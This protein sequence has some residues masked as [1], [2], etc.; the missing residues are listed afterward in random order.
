MHLEKNFRNT[1]FI[2]KEILLITMYTWKIFNMIIYN[3]QMAC[4]INLAP[5]LLS[6]ANTI[7]L[8][9]FCYSY[10]IQ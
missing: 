8:Q 3:A 6:S 10:Y 5:I 9:L 4:I 7:C 1:S 2:H